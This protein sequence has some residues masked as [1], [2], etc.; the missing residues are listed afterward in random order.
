MRGHPK[1][2]KRQKVHRLKNKKPRKISARAKAL[3]DIE[4]AT[5]YLESLLLD[6]KNCLPSYRSADMKRDVKELQIRISSQGLPFVTDVLP[7]LAAG[8]FDQLEGRQA[9]F[10]G[11]KLKGDRPEFLSGLFHIAFSGTE[12]EKIMAI[13]FIYT[14]SVSFKKLKG[15]YKRWKLEKQFNEFVEVDQGLPGVED[16]S[17]DALAILCLARKYMVGI[18][19]DVD[20]NSAAF[21]PRPGPGATNIP[22]QKHRRYRPTVLF[23]QIESAMSFFDGWYDVH[24]W[25]VVL[26]SATYLSMLKS[27]KKRSPV[28]RFKFVPKTAGKA[29]GICIEENEVQF[30]QQ[31]L[32]RGITNMIL[33]DPYLRKHVPLN[34]QSVNAKLALQSS[35]DRRY[36][37]IDMSEASD[38][39]SRSLVDF[40]TDGIPL[41]PMLMALST[42][43]IKPPPEA[44]SR[45]VIS[46][47]KFAPMGSA[48]CFP[49][50]SLVHLVL[51]KAI[52]RLTCTDAPYDTADDVYIYGDDIIIPST[53]YEAVT[54]RLA[55]F[56]MKLNLTKSY[57]HSHF[58]ESCGTHAYN[59][60][61]V[62]PIYI[63]YIP[64]H[65]QV[66]LLET[67]FA[68]E[69][70]LDSKCW[71]HAA[72]TYR[73]WII[74]TYGNF[75]LV[76]RD[77]GLAG[78]L[79][80]RAE[81]SKYSAL[82]INYRTKT[83]YC[84]DTQQHLRKV[85]TFKH[86][87]T[88]LHFDPYSGYLR[89]HL[90]GGAIEASITAKNA[91]NAN[92]V[93]YV[94]DTLPGCFIRQK[95]V[96]VSVCGA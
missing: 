8:L 92:K 77:S 76:P 27:A 7:T 46:T 2:Q 70:Q 63:R 5:Q 50:M 20:P 29:R 95:W 55:W 74:R 87:S 68:T 96:P 12:A 75:P 54:E 40:L 26:Q 24:P 66:S 47:K 90:T 13:Q 31:A 81:V 36:A 93:G 41:N 10:P 3:R 21:R 19:G 61:E 11:F 22:I 44:S 78:F 48:L 65:P 58:R 83:K 49:I 85:K 53:V 88:K 30:L 72:K 59:G 23:H 33:S 37:T 64:N 6:A 79:R 86:R 25:D 71:Y 39:I 60:E 84:P 80:D 34:D 82:R 18:L 1:S 94:E 67:H 91:T 43:Y 69:T 73:E 56:G 4:F 51:V 42:R 57:V 89:W 15:S 52:I 28:S 38:R 9:I 16:L 62:T 14:A 45:N 35:K 17:S 32:R